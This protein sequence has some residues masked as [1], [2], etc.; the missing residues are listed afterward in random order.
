ML[1]GCLEIDLCVTTFIAH[2]VG[3]YQNEQPL[4]DKLLEF[5]KHIYTKYEYY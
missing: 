5:S 3:G 4:A 2:I 1:P